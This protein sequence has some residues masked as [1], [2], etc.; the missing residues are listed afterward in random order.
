MSR[1]FNLAVV[2][3]LIEINHPDLMVGQMTP[4]LVRAAGDAISDVLLDDGFQ[5]QTSFMDGQDVVHCYLNPRT[6][7]ILDDIGFSVGLVNHGNG[8]PSLSVLLR[9]EAPLEVTPAGFSDPLRCA[10]SWYLP[11][12]NSATVKELRSVAGAAHLA[13]CFEWRAVA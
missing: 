12:Y 8:G 1:G 9:T 10:R 3:H 4:R 13:P 7:E 6:G 5:L 11:M 2:Q